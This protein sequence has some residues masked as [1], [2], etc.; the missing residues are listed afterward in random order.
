MTDGIYLFIFFFFLMLAPRRGALLSYSTT[1]LCSNFLQSHFFLLI[2]CLSTVFM[3]FKAGLMMSSFLY[4]LHCSQTRST[5]PA[6]RAFFPTSLYYFVLHTGS[7]SGI[8]QLRFEINQ[9]LLMTSCCARMTSS[10]KVEIRELIREILARTL[11]LKK[12]RQCP[13]SNPRP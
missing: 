7:R 5:L 6:F 2:R 3:I 9:P 10:P 8:H 1:I 12:E 13:G 11:Q 4:D